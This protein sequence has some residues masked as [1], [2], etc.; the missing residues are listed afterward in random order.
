MWRLHD[1]FGRALGGGVIAL[2]VW[3]MPG[4]GWSQLGAPPADPGG[5]AAA[6]GEAKPQFPPLPEPEGARRLSEQDRVWIDVKQHE[7]LI[8]GY[9]ALRRGMLEMFA[10]PSG[11]K[12][13]E[14]IV[15]VHTKAATVHAALLAVGA[16]EGHPVR[17]RPKFAPPEGTE[18]DIV[19]RWRDAAGEWQSAQ[20]QDWVRDVESKKPM[21][22]QW[23][24]AGSGFWTDEK[25]G[26][27]YYM[28][29]QGDLICVS[30]FTTATLDVPFESSQSNE[31]LLFEANT[32]V[33]PPA[34]MPVRVVLK[35]VLQGDAQGG[36]AATPADPDAA[37]DGEDSDG[38]GDQP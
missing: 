37:R 11:T 4:V 7:V 27:R 23:V 29:E 38:E 19:V 16:V 10:C 9:I 28:A 12:E 36:D 1:V 21:S 6:N 31:G 8:D 25:T 15:A 3:L 20:A 26:K 32:D 22:Q 2:A 18:I 30:N 13:H 14:S 24:F 34:G 35:P 5:A 17:Y 33:I